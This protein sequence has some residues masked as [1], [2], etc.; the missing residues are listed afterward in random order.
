MSA[1]ALDGK[2]AIVTGA[3][4][5]IGSATVAAMVAAGARVV[6]ADR[7]TERLAAL[8]AAHDA[9][10]VVTTVVD[11]RDED[12]VRAM[13]GLAVDRFG[14]LDV[15]HDN[16]ANASAGDTDV[17]GTPDEVW[18]DTYQLI[19]MGAVYACRHA[20]PVMAA[21]G[22]GAIVHTSSGAARNATGSRIAYGTS[23]AA[24]ESLSM[25]LA[26]IHGPQGIRSNIVAPGFVLTDGTRALF[27]DAALDGFAARATAGRV[28]RPEDVADVV[29]FLA[30][31]AA[32]YV[33]GQVVPVNGGGARALSW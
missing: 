16:A 20:I 19:V 17:V 29:V 23:K 3:A 7:N 31:D 21:N 30:S 6:A 12:A 13:V 27:D 18:L 22:G 5:A 32:R 33:S 15:L 26:T 9:A 24:L 14:R 10:S 8:A 11:V 28:C 4:G 2:V 25:Y 1:G